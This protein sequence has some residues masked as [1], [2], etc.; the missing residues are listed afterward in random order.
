MDT[1]DASVR[2]AFILAWALAL[3]FYVLEYATRSAPAG[4]LP[5]LQQAFGR[6]GVGVS[7][8]LGSYYYTYSLTSLVAG[9]ALD[10][11]GA[12]YV[13]P[14]G[15]LILAAGCILFSVS[16]PQSA[17]LARLL[18]GAGSAFAFTAAFYL[19]SRGFS[20]SFLATAIG[21]TQCL[22]MLGGSA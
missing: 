4:M 6:D 12:K 19:A 20:S 1:T 3:V 8:I 21:L 5:Q 2:R 15:C 7:N 18:Q 22:G 14:L 10:R 17:Y 11:A 9:V 13:A 16:N